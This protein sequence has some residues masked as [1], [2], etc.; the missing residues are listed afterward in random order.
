[1]KTLPAI[2]KKLLLAFLIGFLFSVTHQLLA[3]QAPDTLKAK[4]LIFLSFEEL[5]N[6][7]IGMGS[8]TDLKY[9]HKPVSLTVIT[10][11][12]ISNTP[13]RNIYDLLEI[14]VPGALWMYHN[15]GPHPGIRG[16]IVD[17]NYKFLLLVNGR[18]MNQKAHN[19]ATSELENWDLGDIERIEIIRGPG[20]VTYGPGA[21]A[22][23]INL[24]TYSSSG[25]QGTRVRYAYLNQ[26]NSNAISISHGTK[27][28]SASGYIYGSLVNTGGIRPQAYS[29]SA[30]SMKSGYM[31]SGFTGTSW[32]SDPQHDYMKDAFGIPQAKLHAELS[33]RNNLSIW[34]RYVSSGT[35][36]GGSTGV[37]PKA[38]YQ[39]GLTLV[40]SIPVYGNFEN[41]R[42]FRNQH[43]TVAVTH[44]HNFQNFLSGLSASSI[45]TWDSENVEKTGAPIYYTAEDGLSPQTQRMIADPRSVLNKSL[46]FSENELFARLLLNLHLNS[47]IQLALGADGAYTNWRAPWG[48]S[49]EELRL[50]DRANIISGENSYIYNV[51]GGITEGYFVGKGWHSWNYSVYSEVNLNLHPLLNIL[52]S[53]RVD[54]NTYSEVLFYPRMAFISEL[55]GNLMVKLVAQNSQRMNTAEQLYVESVEGNVSEPEKLNSVELIVNKLIQKNLQIDFSAFYNKLSTIAWD[56]NNRQSTLIGDLK[57]FGLEGELRYRSRQALFILSHSYVKQIDWKL[58]GGVEWSGISYADYNR[59]ALYRWD[60]TGLL[61]TGTGQNLNNWA[62]H[63]TKLIVQYHL[64]NHIWFHTNVQIFWAYEGG[65]DGLN[66]I[67]NAYANTVYETE[68]AQLM[69]NVHDK[70]AYKT[71]LSL[72]SSLSYRMNEFCTFQ[73]YVINLLNLGNNKR[74]VWDGGNQHLVPAQAIFIEEPRAFGFRLT[75]DF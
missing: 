74:Y 41:S 12:D 33:F 13:A 30:N 8:I 68:S 75:V 32:S 66:M 53:G 36:Y 44:K 7:K 64:N 4:D 40:D 35:M 18:E 49:E 9:S 50:G 29:L 63:S 25:S 5:L 2:H 62:N 6:V 15:E 61:L 45:L 67:E 60:P 56:N 51:K 47:K 26:Y 1:M 24:I 27:L 65:L 57:L 14:Y 23:V 54:K 73:I 43:Y 16:I 48:K 71:N 70:N 10:A 19:G 72:G 17:R 37:L 42:V 20:S 38:R 58:K 3:A 11:D 39:T 46:N 28:G 59:E 21:V 52:I 55:P 34:A 69:Q 31:G 22:G